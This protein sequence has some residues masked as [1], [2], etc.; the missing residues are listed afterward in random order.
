LNANIEQFQ[1]AIFIW[2]SLLGF[3]Q[4][5][6]LAIYYLTTW[7]LVM[8]QILK[9]IRWAFVLIEIAHVSDLAT[10]ECLSYTLNEA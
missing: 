5:P 2:E 10:H 3:S 9:Q 7:L 8:M 6:E 1:Q 4:F